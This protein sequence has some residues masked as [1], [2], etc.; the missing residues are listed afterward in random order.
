MTKKQKAVVVKR[1]LIAKDMVM[2]AFVLSSLALLVLEHIEKL[3][4]EQLLFAEV[5][6]I[7]VGVVFLVEFI[8]ELYFAKD[9]N[10]Y[11]KRHWFYLFAS[12]PLPQQAFA[13]LRGLRVIRLLRLLKIFA[14]LRYENNT[15]L[16]K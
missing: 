9:R 3:T 8:F 13:I 15:R 5:F 10:K 6:D 14:H 1:F 2:Y 11:W 16:I 7:F 4:H 12:V